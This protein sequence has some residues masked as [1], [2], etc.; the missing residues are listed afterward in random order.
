MAK[1]I[2]A[3]NYCLRVINLTIE[4]FD[5]ICYNASIKAQED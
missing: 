2:V 1:I 5:N 3:I 4:I